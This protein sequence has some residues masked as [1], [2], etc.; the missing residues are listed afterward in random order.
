MLLLYKEVDTVVLFGGACAVDTH[1]AY[2]K[3]LLW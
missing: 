2:V 3:G 1:R